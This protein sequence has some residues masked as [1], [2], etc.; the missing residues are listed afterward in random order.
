MIARNTYERHWSDPEITS[1][2]LFVKPGVSTDAIVRELQAK[3]GRSVGE[4]QA[5]RILV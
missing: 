4:G 5:V 2:G 3:L 1:L